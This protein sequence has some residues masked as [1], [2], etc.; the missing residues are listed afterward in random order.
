MKTTAVVEMSTIIGFKV[1]SDELLVFLR[2]VELFGY[3]AMG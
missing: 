2:S 3:G 1:V